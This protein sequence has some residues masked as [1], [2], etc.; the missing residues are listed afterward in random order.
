[1]KIL[2]RLRGLL[3]PIMVSFSVDTNGWETRKR[4][5]WSNKTNLRRLWPLLLYANVTSSNAGESTEGESSVWWQLLG[6]LWRELR[7]GGRLI[8]PCYQDLAFPSPTEELHHHGLWN[9]AASK[10]VS[11]FIIWRHRCC[12]L[13]QLKTHAH[14]KYRILTDLKYWLL[15]PISNPIS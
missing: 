6:G 2:E 4:S 14:H 5:H 9:M 15:N 12:T 3:R 1:M 13:H 10:A 11:D 8:R 7:Q